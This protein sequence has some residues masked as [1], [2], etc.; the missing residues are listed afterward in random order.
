MILTENSF[1]VKFFSIRYV[2]EVAT[3]Y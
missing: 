2:D 1:K 3:H